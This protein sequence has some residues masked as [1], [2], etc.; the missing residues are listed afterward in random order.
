[1]IREGLLAPEIVTYQA[2]ERAGL[3]TTGAASR[4]SEETAC[5]SLEDGTIIVQVVDMRKVAGMS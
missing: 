2:E 1:M 3:Y 5:A 4:P